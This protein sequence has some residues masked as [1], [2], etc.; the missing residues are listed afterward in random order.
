MQVHPTSDRNSADSI[1]VDSQ[2]KEASQG[3]G[4]LYYWFSTED[5][6][7]E[8]VNSKGDIDATVHDDE[9]SGQSHT[10]TIKSASIATHSRY[11]ELHLSVK[12]KPPSSGK[13]VVPLEASPS[14]K[15]VQN[16]TMTMKQLELAIVKY[17]LQIEKYEEVLK[18]LNDQKAEI[19]QL[20]FGLEG[21]FFYIF[22][23]MK[24]NPT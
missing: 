2:C 22:F 4:M 5:V 16:L 24:T 13:M 14:L 18:V 10:L 1:P 11:S 9:K 15:N 8:I 12:N 23:F 20:L 19:D 6:F 17:G 7:F 21:L 3:I